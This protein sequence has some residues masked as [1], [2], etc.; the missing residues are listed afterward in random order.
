MA[1]A[2]RLRRDRRSSV[3][4][5]GRRRDLERSV[6]AAVGIYFVVVPGIERGDF[7]LTL[8]FLADLCALI[9]AAAGALSEQDRE[10]RTI[11]IAL[12]GLCAG[13]AVGD[14]L[15]ARATFVHGGGSPGAT[16]LAWGVAAVALGVATIS[17]R[18][19]EHDQRRDRDASASW[20]GARIVFPFAVV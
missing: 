12:G 8:V 16:A 5:G 6:V 4:D 18:R 15:V 10:Q 7:A 19:E 20:V 1:G 9:V 13:A 3:G 14:G 11:G 17:W 2:R